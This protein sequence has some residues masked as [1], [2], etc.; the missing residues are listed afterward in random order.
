MTARKDHAIF[1]FFAFRTLSWRLPAIESL[2]SRPTTD[3]LASTHQ[4]RSLEPTMTGIPRTLRPSWYH[5]IPLFLVMLLIHNGPSRA[6]SRNTINSCYPQSSN[7]QNRTITL[8][9]RSFSSPKSI[10]YTVRSI[11]NYILP[12]G[13]E[14]IVPLRRRRWSEH[15]DVLILCL[16]PGGP[17][18]SDETGRGKSE[19]SLY[20]SPA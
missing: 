9:D 13:A 19:E 18:T 14:S 4:S 11:C 3:V 12:F 8:P 5:Q 16:Q 6:A 20:R 17:S 15:I 10:W 1:V 2:F 7:C